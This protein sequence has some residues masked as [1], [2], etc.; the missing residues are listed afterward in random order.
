[1]KTGIIIT[2]LI[3]IVGLIIFLVPIPY[4][5]IEVYKVQE[6]YITKETY[7]ENEI[8]V[9]TEY[10]DEQVPFTE[11]ECKKDISVNPLDYIN[12]GIK[13][14]DSLLGGD[15]DALL[16]TCETVIKSKTVEKSREVVKRSEERRV[17][18]ECRSRW[19]PYH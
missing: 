11:E 15:I 3:L 9:E 14:I 5:A 10:Y 1:M 2:G 7:I 17:G 8:Y 4:T 13:N 18:K 16:E 6:E 12:R 19:S